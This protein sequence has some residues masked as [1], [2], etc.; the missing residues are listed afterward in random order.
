MPRV[1]CIART[2]GLYEAGKLHPM[3]RGA[4]LFAIG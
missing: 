3:P 1:F 4:A 2:G